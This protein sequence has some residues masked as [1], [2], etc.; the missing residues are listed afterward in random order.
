MIELPSWASPWS[1]HE[2]QVVGRGDGG[3]AVNVFGPPF[4]GESIRDQH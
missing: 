2:T 1:D 3:V 4:A